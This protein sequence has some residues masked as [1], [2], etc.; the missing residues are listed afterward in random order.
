MI[1]EALDHLYILETEARNSMNAAA[2]DSKQEDAAVQRHRYV[3]YR[4][5]C[6]AGFCPRNMR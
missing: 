1:R 2:A 5:D 3:L 4:V 6:S